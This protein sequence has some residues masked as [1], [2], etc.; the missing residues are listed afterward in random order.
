MGR[1]GLGGSFRLAP[2]GT[3]LLPRSCCLFQRKSRC[4][5]RNLGRL[6]VVREVVA[7][8][9]SSSIPSSSSTEGY[10]APP[11]GGAT[12]KTFKETAH[13]KKQRGVVL[14]ARVVPK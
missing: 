12:A 2:G 8:S 9:K 14:T 7:D 11:G 13:E 10:Q 5:P 6:E 1:E 4:R 3:L